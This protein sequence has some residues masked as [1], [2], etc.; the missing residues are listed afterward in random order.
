MIRIE[1]LKAWASELGASAAG[2]REVECP[3][4]GP[5]PDPR[6]PDLWEES[7]EPVFSQ[8]CMH[9]T[10]GKHCA[11]ISTVVI[12]RWRTWDF[13]VV[14]VKSVSFKVFTMNIYYSHNK[15]KKL[16]LKRQIYSTA[17]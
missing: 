15:G 7:P 2:G 16:F 10:V 17:C 12:S 1:L 8:I 6:N 4:S 5:S 9:F 11:G 14:V 13:Y 3:L